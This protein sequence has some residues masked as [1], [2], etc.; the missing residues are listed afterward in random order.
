[1]NATNLHGSYVNDLFIH[2]NT[3]QSR[4]WELLSFPWTH[5]VILIKLTQRLNDLCGLLVIVYLLPFINLPNYCR[6]I[7]RYKH[8]MWHT[9]SSSS[10]TYINIDP[11][12]DICEALCKTNLQTN[13]YFKRI[14]FKV[15]L[16]ASIPFHPL[17]CI[18]GHRG[19]VNTN[20]VLTVSEFEGLAIANVLCNSCYR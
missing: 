1:M 3:S 4:L 8:F 2:Q 13:S 15:I 5:F 12:T 9:M 11:N 6:V 10:L 14:A 17:H 18:M 16:L 20:M 19:S 7:S